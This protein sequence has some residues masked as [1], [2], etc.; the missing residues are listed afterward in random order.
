MTLLMVPMLMVVDAAAAADGDEL[1]A[2]HADSKRAPEGLNRQPF[3]LPRQAA[4]AAAAAAA[5]VSGAQSPAAPPVLQP[6]QP[7]PQQLL[8]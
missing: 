4:A 7:Q 5:A 8:G 6:Q 3:A 1:I 2:A